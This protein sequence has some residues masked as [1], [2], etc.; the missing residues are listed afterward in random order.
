[1]KCRRSPCRLRL[2]PCANFVFACQNHNA[3]EVTNLRIRSRSRRRF[4]SSCLRDD[5]ASPPPPPPPP[6]SSIPELL[7]LFGGIEELYL[8]SKETKTVTCVLLHRFCQPDLCV[9]KMQKNKIYNREQLRQTKCCLNALL[10]MYRLSAMTLD[11]SDLSGR[12]NRA[13]DLCSPS[14]PT[15]LERKKYNQRSMQQRHRKKC[16]TLSITHRFR[17]SRP[18]QRCI[19]RASSRACWQR[20][21]AR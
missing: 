15:N 17:S 6:T 3:Q 11:A 13:T 20:S 16:K 1:V 21:P 9:K 4:R 7:M 14:G 18:C 19:C 5:S 10:W 2:V 8:S 12:R